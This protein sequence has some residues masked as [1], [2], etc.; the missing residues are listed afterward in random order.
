MR[1]VLEVPLALGLEMALRKEQILEMYLNGV[2][3]G[4]AGTIGIAGVA[5]A[6][7]WY[8]DLPNMDSLRLPRP[9]HVIPRPTCTIRSNT[10][11]R[12]AC[13]ATRC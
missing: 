10:P 6:A 8:F 11:P 1:K 12:R 13:V 5:E 9:R 7:R 3:L 2:Y 4:Q